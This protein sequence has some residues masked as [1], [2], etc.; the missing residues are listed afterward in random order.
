MINIMILNGKIT[1]NNNIKYIIHFLNNYSIDL[2]ILCISP[3]DFIK[4]KTG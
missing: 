1:M 3:V 4:T 2:N